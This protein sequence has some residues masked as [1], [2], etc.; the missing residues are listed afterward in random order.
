MNKLVCSI[1]MGPL[2]HFKWLERHKHN[3]A[4]NQSLWM[5]MLFSACARH[6][7]SSYHFHI[8]FLSSEMMGWSMKK[9]SQAICFQSIGLSGSM[10][11]CLVFSHCFYIQSRVTIRT[12]KSY[13]ITN[14]ML[15]I[16]KI[17]IW[18][19]G[20]WNLYSQCLISASFHHNLIPADV[21]TGLRQWKV[22]CQTCLANHSLPWEG[23][24]IYIH[25][26]F[27]S[28]N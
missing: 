8:S 12:C 6:T 14:L 26:R 17:V 27:F 11:S 24:S 20:V 3:V 9:R 15:A 18:R 25:F 21:F 10:I 23:L 2:H 13:C 19:L 16:L 1:E 4:E 5:F 22:I 28:Q 7:I